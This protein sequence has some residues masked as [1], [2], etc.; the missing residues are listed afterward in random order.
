M[1]KTFRSVLAP[2]LSLSIL[3]MGNAFFTTYT[4]LKLKLSGFSIELIGYS[5]SAYFAGLL[6][7]SL[8]CSSFIERIGHIRAYATLAAL[9]AVIA[10]IQA[11]F[12]QGWVWI[13]IRFLTGFFIAGL[14][15][16]IESW[17][18]A[19]S[20]I[21]TKGKVLSIYMISYYG[22]QT[23]AQFLLD[24]SDLRTVIPFCIIVIL[25]TSSI[26]PICMTRIAA[27]IIQEKSY[28]K[29]QHL[30]K[31]APLGVI[32]ALLSG[33]I[34]GPIYGLV[35]IYIKDIGFSMKEVA[36]GMGITI[37]G[38]LILQWPIGQISDHV[39]RRK[40]LFT[41]SFLAAIISIVFAINSIHTK[42]LIYFLL[43]FLGGF[44]FSI[45]PIAISHSTDIVKEKDTI[46]AIAAIVLIYSIGAIIGPI[47]ASYGMDFLGP[48]GLFIYMSSIGVILGAYSFYRYLKIKEIPLE[49][50][51]PYRNIPRT[52][53]LATEL[54]PK[55]KEKNKKD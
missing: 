7:G 36:L 17:L 28:F 30:C 31:I 2:I 34:C 41:I 54:Y 32:G 8:R 26:V 20:T 37:F 42:V 55:E 13:I 48:R 35:P 22:S 12:A 24:I 3:I 46:S 52:T 19:K 10:M 47:L 23:I 27:P 33:L 5:T 11:I 43:A 53:P 21:S 16:T 6:I 51:T 40:V 25:F 38:G 45:Y 15:V 49:E 14:F 1:F 4:S 50:K 39:D 29:I 9:L 18:L 44:S